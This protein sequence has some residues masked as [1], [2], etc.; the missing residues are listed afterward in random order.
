MAQQRNP[1]L[2]NQLTPDFQ[3]RYEP[4]F[5]MAQINAFIS[6]LPGLVGWWPF[7]AINGSGALQSQDGFSAQ[8]TATGTPSHGYKTSP[9]LAPF[10]IYDGASYHSIASTTRY[11]ISGTEAHVASNAQGL[12]MGCIVNTDTIAS[13]AAGRYAFCKWGSSI[14][15]AQYRL[16]LTVTGGAFQFA[17]S[18]GVNSFVSNS[19]VSPSASTWYFLAGRYTPSTEVAT[20]VNDSKTTNTTS[21]PASLNTTAQTLNIG[22]RSDGTQFWDGRISMAWLCSMA[23]EDYHIFAIYEMLR[24]VFGL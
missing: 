13:T 3:R 22:S 12:T 23:L 5:G 6:Q 7:S 19:T 2:V 24:P 10:H 1:A 18:N 11:N 17:V 21:I 8:M 14:A 20:W 15:N 9:S 4:Q 16:I